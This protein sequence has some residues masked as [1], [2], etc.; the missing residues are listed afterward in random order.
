MYE[1]RQHMLLARPAFARRVLMH[2]GAAGTLVSVSLLAGVLGYRE[3][4]SL[5]WTDAILNASMILAGMGPVSALTTEAGK[6]FA[7]GFALY[8]GLL[9][10]VTAAVVF[11]P[12][13][14][15]L[16]HRFHMT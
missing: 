11:A 8:S 7:A 14:H 9:F 1:K 10:L 3:L 6:L 13:I 15:R 5:S 4:E 12:L 16:L 2:A